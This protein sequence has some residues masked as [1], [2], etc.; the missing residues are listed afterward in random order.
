MS[1]LV[2][3]YCG[4]GKGKTTAAMGL[5]VRCAGWQKRVL[6][7]QLMKQDNS[8]ERR[9]LEQLPQVTLWQTYPSAKFSFRMTD[10][11]KQAA[12]EWYTAQFRKIAETVQHGAYA[13]LVLD[14]LHYL[15]IPAGTAGAGFSGKPSGGAGG[16]DYRA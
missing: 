7:A 9:I 6:V 5:A 13:M 10:A 3:I 4:D 14:E 15:R 1:G 16:C 8:G 11:E 12:A 2:H